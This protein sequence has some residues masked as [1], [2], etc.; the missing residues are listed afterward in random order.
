MHSEY[1]DVLNQTI[2]VPSSLHHFSNASFS[3]YG[4][5]SY[6]RLV[7]VKEEVHWEFVTGKLRVSIDEYHNPSLRI[8]GDVGI[9]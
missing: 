5:C 8:D 6:I 3:G 7:N 9:S 1:D 4:Q 2:S